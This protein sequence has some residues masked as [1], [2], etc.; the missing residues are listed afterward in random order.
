MVGI[1]S[2]WVNSHRRRDTKGRDTLPSLPVG[3]SNRREVER[4]LPAPPTP[5]HK[6]SLVQSLATKGFEGLKGNVGACSKGQEEEDGG[7]RQAGHC[8]FLG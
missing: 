2:E 1:G 3:H 8:Y 5:I 7:D 6:Y 4:Y